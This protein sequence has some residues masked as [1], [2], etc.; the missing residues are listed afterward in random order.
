MLCAKSDGIFT[1]TALSSMYT[2]AYWLVECTFARPRYIACC[3]RSDRRLFTGS[4]SRFLRKPGIGRRR[5]FSIDK[6]SRRNILPST[7]FAQL[8]RITAGSRLF[9]ESIFLW[10][11]L[12]LPPVTTFEC[13]GIRLA[14]KGSSLVVIAIYRPGSVRPSAAFF[15]DLSTLLES[16]SLLGCPFVVGGNLNIHVEDPGDSD[17]VR[18][19]ELLDLFGLIQTSPGSWRHVGPS[20]R[21][22]GHRRCSNRHSSSGDHLRAR[23][24]RR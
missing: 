3:L 19:A 11:R 7:K 9:F 4:T 8:I 14:V 1:F 13:L 24:S 5:I 18:L 2:S 12:S 16:V 21:A 10:S 17:G 6:P 22:T 23:P 20:R 15:D